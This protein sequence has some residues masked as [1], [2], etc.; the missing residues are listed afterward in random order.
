MVNELL[1]TV[2]IMCLVRVESAL[3]MFWIVLIGRLYS[4]TR[5]S[6][7]GVYVFQSFLYWANGL[8]DVISESVMKKSI[9]LWSD[10]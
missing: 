9:G 8:N 2:V 1:S 4:L 7:V 3:S 5:F 6:R 10:D